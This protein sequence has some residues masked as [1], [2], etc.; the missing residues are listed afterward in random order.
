MLLILIAFENFSLLVFDSFELFFF[1][2][3]DKFSTVSKWQC[4]DEV[5]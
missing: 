4:K 1:Y 2:I 5:V 3:M